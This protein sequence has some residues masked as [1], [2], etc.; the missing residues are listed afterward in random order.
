MLL[1]DVKIRTS[2]L[3]HITLVKLASDRGSLLGAPCNAILT[4]IELNVKGRTGDCQLIK[5]SNS[6]RYSKLGI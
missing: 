4:F 6:E 3:R 1:E 5:H 2:S